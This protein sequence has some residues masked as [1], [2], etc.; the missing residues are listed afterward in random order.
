MARLAVVRGWRAYQVGYC[1]LHTT[2]PFHVEDWVLAGMAGGHFHRNPP[3]LAICT[4]ERWQPGWSQSQK[5]PHDPPGDECSCGYYG[6][7]QPD[8]SKIM[9]SYPV[10]WLRF[11]ALGD[12]IV[13]E[14]DNRLTGFRCQTFQAHDLW[15]PS[16]PSSGWLDWKERLTLLLPDDWKVYTASVAPSTMGEQLPRIAD[17]LGLP[18][19]R[20]TLMGD[21]LA[22]GGVE[23]GEI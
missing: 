1:P 4:V 2:C 20:E 19:R 8:Q 11:T 6:L 12:T 3:P 23:W 10:V 17:A 18:L 7:F 15:W 5:K 14:E 16:S 13:A 21:L 22:W 9:M